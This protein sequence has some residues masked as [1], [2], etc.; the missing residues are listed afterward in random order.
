MPRSLVPRICVV[1]EG[2]G[3]G[4]SLIATGLVCA[5]KARGVSVAC[6]VRG[7]ALTQALIYSRV[8]RRYAR[9]VSGNLLSMESIIETIGEAGIGADLVV[10]DGHDG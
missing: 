7:E 1:G 10:I 9:C 2:R 8:A 3:I 6:C 5:L 4:K